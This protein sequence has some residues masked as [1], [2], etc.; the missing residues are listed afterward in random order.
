MKLLIAVDSSPSSETVIA[1]IEGRP[2]PGGTEAIVLNVVDI[3]GPGSGVMD[4]GS[5]LEM[6]RENAIQLV[7]TA[8]GRLGSAGLQATGEVIDGVP[9][10]AID[11]Y[12][13]EW[14]ADFIIMG[15][16]GHSDLVRFLLGSVAKSVLRSAPCSVEIVRPR[17]DTVGPAKKPADGLMVILAT[18]GSEHSQA[19]ARSIAE[20]P[21]PAKSEFRV[22]SF[23]E[24]PPFVQPPHQGPDQ[25]STLD[26][27]REDIM[28]RAEGAVESARALLEKAGLATTGAAV[29]GDPRTGILDEGT[30]WAADLIVLGSHGTARADGVAPGRTAETVALHA[31]CSVEIIRAIK[32]ET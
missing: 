24:L 13:K 15:S 1:V 16:H 5:I 6:E 12:A 29:A 14:G 30:R 22:V 25:D 17:A 32:M 20:R 27:I 19:A 7:D 3:I 10:S 4:V 11:A 18:D 31:H 8:A 23:A 26:A 21:W 28:E 2:W 9:R